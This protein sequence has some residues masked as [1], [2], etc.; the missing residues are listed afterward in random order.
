MGAL[1]VN[2]EEFGWLV[3]RLETQAANAPQAFR[4]KVFLISIAG[5]VFLAAMLLLVVVVLAW[6]AMHAH[7]PGMMR[8][9]VFAGLLALMT[10]PIFWVTLRTLFTRWPAPTGRVLTRAEAPVLFDML[11][12]M[13]AKL[14]GPPIHHVLIDDDYNACIVQRPRWGLVGPSVNYLVLGLPF[15]VSMGTSEML[16]VIGHEY[17]HL[18]GAHGR[19]TG[20]IYR[21]RRIFEQV[22]TRIDDD[23]GSTIWHAAM[24]KAMQAFAPYFYGYTFV[25]GRQMEYEADRAGAGVTNAQ[26]AASG[27][28][29]SELLG[30]WLHQDFWPTLY[31]QADTREQPTI[32]PYQAMAIAFRMSH[33]EWATPA[34]LRS[35]WK[36][37]SGVADTH[38]CLRDR[39]EALGQQ[40]ALPA[41]L[42]RS[43]ATALL[44]PLGERLAADFDHAWWQ[45]ESKAWGERHRHVTRSQMRLRELTSQPMSTMQPHELQELARLKSEFESNQ[46]AKPVL[47][48]LLHRQG[49]PF[50]LASYV[51]G[52]ILLDEHNRDGLDYLATAAKH[53]R[54]LADQAL[55][56]GITY[57]LEQ[58]G[59]ERA[60][61]WADSVL[62]AVPG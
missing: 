31:R 53:D 44:G 20:W 37:V 28:I 8:T 5:Y 25:L 13:R 16:S 55:N 51:Y 50:P 9:A 19:A 34:R 24:N 52:Q 21:Q 4:L 40:P 15:M 10:L 2:D 62:E 32:L 56:I 39:V 46:A 54:R 57:L 6:A 35:A 26:A 11:D 38:P 12:K 61:K 30:D 42:Q 36:Q 17:G 48:H 47:E 27:L 14:A 7:E 49:G 43:A 45:S 1:R 60:Q 23:A 41:Q 22:A 3:S 59:E 58:H 33:D 18:C 29:R